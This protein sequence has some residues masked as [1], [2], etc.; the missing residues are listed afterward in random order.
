[1]QDEKKTQVEF[2]VLQTSQFSAANCN[3]LGK[4]K[5]GRFGGKERIKPSSQSY[6]RTIKDGLMS[7]MG[8]NEMV[9]FNSRR[10]PRLVADMLESAHGFTKEKAEKD[11]ASFF[12]EFFKGSKEDKKE[13]SP[14]DT[15]EKEEIEGAEGEPLEEGKGK[16]ELLSS[17]LFMLSK[18]HSKRIAQLISDPS[19][20]PKERVNTFKKEIA[21]ESG[22]IS[23]FFGRMFASA[24]SCN[25]EATL[26]R[27]EAFSTHEAEEVYDSFTAV[28]DLLGQNDSG[29]G[30]MGDKTLYSGCLY[31]NVNWDFSEW[32]DDNHIGSV[33]K[34]MSPKD[35][36]E[37]ISFLVR[38]MVKS[39]ATAM[40]R[41]KQ[42]SKFSQNLP[43]LVLVNVI[44]GGGTHSLA[45]AF[46]QPVKASKDGGYVQ[47]SIDALLKQDKNDR[48]SGFKSY[49]GS[50]MYVDSKYTT[51]DK[52][53]SV[54]LSSNIND[55]VDNLVKLIL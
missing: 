32:M 2:H 42:S 52:D 50:Y 55:V 19:L 22:I 23:S 16:D 45:L 21:E 20:S 24:A 11:V 9:D 46:E 6:S 1:M 25:V 33:V 30:H 17:V 35:A 12:K 3:E 48:H 15:E 7:E 18:K 36:K 26:Q 40:P 8:E 5:T 53:D 44:E 37:F 27:S 29:A 38:Y 31:K 39:I 13:S 43:S 4:P 41:G 47:N 51:S 10:H 14:E 34:D 54:K 28:D 49:A